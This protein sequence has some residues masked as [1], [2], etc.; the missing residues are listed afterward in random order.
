MKRFAAARITTGSA[1]LVGAAAFLAAPPARA[2]DVGKV[3]GT[4][5]VLDVTETTIVAQHFDARNAEL[6]Q[7]S[8][9][10]DWLNRLNAV[11]RW[12]QWT[13][14]LRIDSQV[15]WRRPV[16][17]PNFSALT[18]AL[19]TQVVVDNESRF[20]TSVYPAKVW[21]TF[22]APGV[23]VTVGDSY[24]QFG[25]GLVLSLRKLDELGVDTTLRGLKVRVERDPFAFTWVAGFGNP[26]RVDEATGRALFVTVPSAGG[27]PL[28]LFGSDRIIGAEIQAGRGLPVSLATHAVQFVRCAPYSYDASGRPVTDLSADPSGVLLG[29][30]NSTDTAIWL[31][32]LP[33][34][35]TSLNAREITMVGQSIEVPSLWGHGKFYAEAAMQQRVHD[36][37]AEDL[38][39]NGNALYAALSLDAGPASATFELKSNRNFYAV[40]AAINLTRASEFIVDTYSFLPPAE[41]MNQLDTEFGNFN[42]CVDAGRLRGDYRLTNNVMLWAQGVYAY[43]RSEQDAGCDE[44]GNTVG[45]ADPASVQ[46]RVWDGVGGFEW[47]FDEESSHVYASVGARDDTKATG[48]FYYRELHAE[49]SVAKVI[50]GPLS[51]EIQGRHR[52]RKEENTN[53]LPV[54]GTY[55]EQWWHEGEN[56]VALKVAPKWVFTQGFEYTTLTGQPTYY[57]NGAAIYKFTSGS[58]VRLFVG[59]QRGAFRC[60]SG[61]CRYFPP[62]EGARAEL[63]LRF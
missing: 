25:R 53:L 38:H 44:H 5:L 48:D 22:S 11:L 47:Y 61:V 3:N 45:A 63:T 9:W 10:G 49:Y 55:A 15:Y 26:T 8:G 41:T 19:Q 50:G 58:N 59:Q 4:D 2:V 31:A 52:I 7:D 1:A 46:N 6:P 12:G 56:Y 34:S 37:Q 30:C 35:P 39:G 33:N 17:N 18:P 13:A 62:F 36:T 60:A 40:P 21:G 28:A 14:G 51:V 23:E 29:S 24:A 57:L 32:S 16:D 42:A 43:S 27:S 54:G 20:Q